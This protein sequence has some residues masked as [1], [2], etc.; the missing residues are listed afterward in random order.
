MPSN[1]QELLV[2]RVGFGTGWDIIDV[3]YPG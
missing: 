1:L 2:S 3:L